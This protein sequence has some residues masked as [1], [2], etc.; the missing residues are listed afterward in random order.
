MIMVYI[1]E[2]NA[3]REKTPKLLLISFTSI[4]TR[5][6]ISGNKSYLR[7][8]ANIKFLEIMVKQDVGEKLR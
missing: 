1:A 3:N 5:K 2:L 4:K 8:N 6:S 7:T